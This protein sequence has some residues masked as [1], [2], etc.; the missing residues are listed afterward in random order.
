MVN[1]ELLR[2]D[3]ILMIRPVAS[4][5]AADFQQIAQEVDPYIEANGKLHGLLIDAEPLLAGKFLP[6]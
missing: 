4:L 6:P 3:G 5:E 2:P 1:Y